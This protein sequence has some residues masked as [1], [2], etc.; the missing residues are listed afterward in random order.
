MILHCTIALQ[1]RYG[2]LAKL[3]PTNC[4]STVCKLR[5]MTT[6]TDVDERMSNLLSEC[7]DARVINHQLLLYIVEKCNGNTVLLF[8]VLEDVVSGNKKNQL[9]HLGMHILYVR[10]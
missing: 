10:I 3:L 2:E 4:Y 1:E 6:F 7:D 5:T 9:Q 8:N